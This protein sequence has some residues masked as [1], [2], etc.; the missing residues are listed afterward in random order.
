MVSTI[1]QYSF[2][3]S[4]QHFPD[5][6][7][8]K[9]SRMDLTLPAKLY[10]FPR[11]NKR[12]PI[13]QKS[14]RVAVTGLW[15]S[16]WRGSNGTRRAGVRKPELRPLV[17][18][19]RDTRDPGQLLC[20]PLSE[21]QSGKPGRRIYKVLKRIKQSLEA[22]FTSVRPTK[23]YLYSYHLHYL[24]SSVRREIFFLWQL[25]FRKI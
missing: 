13:S 9:V 22:T 5:Q 23:A 18:V 2:R 25:P 12:S 4:R 8:C 14:H 6:I 17:E 1:D 11:N 7:E 16:G 24:R 20:S 19:P 21:S 10:N 3:S 15:L